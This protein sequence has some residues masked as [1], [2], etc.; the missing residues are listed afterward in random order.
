MFILVNIDI[1]KVLLVIYLYVKNVKNCF[2]KYLLLSVDVEVDM[3]KVS[4]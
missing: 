4:N 1:V 2:G 3:F